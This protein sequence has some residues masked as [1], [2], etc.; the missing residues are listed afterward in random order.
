[1]LKNGEKCC[2]D[3]LVAKKEFFQYNSLMKGKMAK[4]ETNF[5]DIEV[6]KV[7]FFQ[8]VFIKFCKNEH[9]TVIINGE[10]KFEISNIMLDG[11]V[12]KSIALD[13]KGKHL[14]IGITVKVNE[15]KQDPVEMVVDSHKMG[16][17]WIKRKE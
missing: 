9:P 13:D 4:Q 12:V 17:T 6:K 16:M 10:E 11:S 1:M 3:F 2:T 5:D 15:I 7:E 8:S 14:D